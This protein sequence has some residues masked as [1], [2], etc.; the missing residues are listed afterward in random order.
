MP[1]IGFWVFYESSNYVMKYAQFFNDLTGFFVCWPDSMLN[2]YVCS[3]RIQTR[4]S[5]S[6]NAYT[7]KVTFSALDSK[8]LYKQKNIIK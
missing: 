5:Q 6:A 1:S 7:C 4:D 3:T 8:L 2:K